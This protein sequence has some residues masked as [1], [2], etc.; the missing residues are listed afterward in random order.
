MCECMFC[1]C[2]YVC[3]NAVMLEL[4]TVAM[5]LAVPERGCG[6]LAGPLSAGCVHWAVPG[7][8]QHADLTRTST[9]A[10]KNVSTHTSD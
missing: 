4:Q 5:S 8:V 6:C 2:V 3:V 1:M 7:E 10:A 9:H